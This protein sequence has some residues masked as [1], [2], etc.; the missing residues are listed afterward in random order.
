MDRRYRDPAGFDSH[1]Q[2]DWFLDETPAIAKNLDK[3][4]GKLVSPQAYEARKV[5]LRLWII[6]Q[7]DNVKALKLEGEGKVRDNFTYVYLGEVAKKRLR[8]LVTKGVVSEDALVA[9]KR[10]AMVDETPCE[11]PDKEV[12]ETRIEGNVPASRF[13]QFYSGDVQLP[14]APRPVP[15]NWD[16][17]EAHSQTFE[18]LLMWGLDN[19]KSKATIVE[20]LW[21]Y[22]GKNYKL[23]CEFYDRFLR[24]TLEGDGHICSP[25]VNNG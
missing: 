6:T 20:A 25:I 18:E 23:G 3:W 22:K 19:H 9:Y 21:G 8:Y 12:L 11:V 1:E 17:F 14:D 4:F 24:E 7:N 10:L 15:K 2:H 16:D 13:V 5:K